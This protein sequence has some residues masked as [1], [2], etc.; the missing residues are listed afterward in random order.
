MAVGYK[1]IIGANN[2]D[3]KGLFS[4]ASTRVGASIQNIEKDFWVCW[5]LGLLFNE[6]TKSKDKRLLFKGGTSLS[7]SYGLISRFSEDIDIT[8]FRDDIN[9][10]HSID[11][12]EGLGTKQK[13]KHLDSIKGACRSYINGEFKSELEN[14]IHTILESCGQSLDAVVILQDDSDPD[15]Q[16]LLIEYPTVLDQSDE[17]HPSSVKVEAGAKSSCDPN[18]LTQIK[19][20]IADDIDDADLTVS[21]VVT[22]KAERTF[23]DKVIILHGQRCHYE[24]KNELKR[25]GHRVSRHYYDIYCLLEN[26]VGDAASK[27]IELAMDCARHT[28]MF[29][30]SKTS[31]LE[32]ALPGSFKLTPLPEME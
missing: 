3:R 27:D 19:P 12:L 8:V 24:N 4:T 13:S 26:E 22:I 7:K 23:W 2:E 29:F 10:S 31:N 6:Q 1:D 14:S 20:Y 11:F 28:R 21:N 30:N 9:Q 25:N 5:V 32:T 16:T 17:Y 18:R 15:E